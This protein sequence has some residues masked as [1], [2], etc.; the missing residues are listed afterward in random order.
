MDATTDATT[1]GGPDHMV[2][3]DTGELGPVTDCPVCAALRASMGA[4]REQH[5][6]AMEVAEGEAANPESD[7]WAPGMVHPNEFLAVFAQRKK[8]EDGTGHTA[9]GWRFIRE[10]RTLAK[11]F[12]EDPRTKLF[13]EEFTERF[14]G[15]PSLEG[16]G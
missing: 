5:L 15:V 4:L 10:A 14:L 1:M 16:A 6:A 2:S 13:W 7:E 3:M 8:H 11:R 9:F 12:A